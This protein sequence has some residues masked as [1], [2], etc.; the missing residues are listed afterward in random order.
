M[1]PRPFR[2]YC[3]TALLMLLA[4][5]IVWFDAHIAQ[6][7]IGHRLPGDV[8]KS[9]MLFEAF[10]HATGVA[11]MLLAVWILDVDRRRCVWRL[12]ACAAGSSLIVHPLKRLV[13]RFRPSELAA[14]LPDPGDP[15]L[16]A[17]EGWFP[18]WRT[19]EWLQL[20]QSELQ[21]FP[22]GHAAVAAGFAAG[23]AF[24]YPRGRYLFAGLAGLAALQRLASG[25]HYA[26]DVL[27]GAA[28]GCLFAAF[29]L[30]PRFLG[31]RFDRLETKRG[32]AVQET[33]RVRLSA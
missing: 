24:C 11:V 14:Q 3:T 12:A 22:S 5:A 32:L 7:T 13:G 2:L 15:G 10:G 27:V 26:S 19:G 4:L 30:D 29:C 1:A 28:L 31:R 18:A 23:L 9:L 8:R 25:A 21:S 16:A 17:W 33:T 20:V 6:W